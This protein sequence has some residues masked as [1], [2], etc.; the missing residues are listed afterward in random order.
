MIAVHFR[1][2]FCRAFGKA[3]ADVR[4]VSAGYH[5]FMRVFGDVVLDQSKTRSTDLMRE[6]SLEW[7]E[8]KTF[9]RATF[10]VGP[11]PISIEAGASGA[12]GFGAG[13][14]I[15]GGVIEGYGDLFFAELDAYAEGGVDVGIAS[16][17]IGAEL[18]LLEHRFRVSGASDLSQVANRQ[19][20]LSALAQNR[21]K[22]IKGEFYL[23]VNY[24]Y[25]KFCC[26]I[27]T[28]RKELTLYKTVLFLTKNGI[29]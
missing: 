14:A 20:T 3:E 8:E 22:A 26:R 5:G 18:L 23:F 25:F 19:I 21:L 16:G 2:L 7:K 29:C 27:K 4:K 15:S 1:T 17:G 28:A 10:F 11:I 13:L 12:M 6:R 24:P 9:A